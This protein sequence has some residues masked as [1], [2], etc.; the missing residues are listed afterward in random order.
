MFVEVQIH[1][2][3]S[4]AI[5]IAYFLCWCGNKH[6][7]F[8]RFTFLCAYSLATLI[9]HFFC[10]CYVVSVIFVWL[11]FLLQLFFVVIFYLLQQPSRL[12]CF[13]PPLSL[14]KTRDK[15]VR[16]NLLW[17]LLNQITK[18][19]ALVTNRSLGKPTCFNTIKTR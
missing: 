5:E 17:F 10:V 4:N 18:S 6:V 9:R 8:D 7:D 11:D 3:L 14:P 13:S 2:V 19:I 16:S 12:I 15:C 1:C